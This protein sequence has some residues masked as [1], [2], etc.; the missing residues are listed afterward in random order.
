MD[1]NSS[2]LHVYENPATLFTILKLMN[3]S[4]PIHVL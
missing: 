2:E 4:I 3:K 1:Q